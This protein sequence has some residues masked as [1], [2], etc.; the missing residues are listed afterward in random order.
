M[1]E[2]RGRSPH[3]FLLSQQ[4][5]SE[6]TGPVELASLGKGHCARQVSLLPSWHCSKSHTHTDT[7]RAG[8]SRAKA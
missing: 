2:Q 6:G 3:L 8:A 7:H 5:S 1:G 4:L